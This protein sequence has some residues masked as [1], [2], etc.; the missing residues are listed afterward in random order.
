MKLKRTLALIALTVLLAVSL[1]MFGGSKTKAAGPVCSVPGDYASIQAAVNDPGCLQINVAAGGYTENVVVNRAVVL[2]GAQAGNPVSGR[3][4][5][6]AAESTLT[7][8]I[9]V[10]AAG[11][12]ID[13]FSQTNPGQGFG[14]LIKTAGSNTVIKNNIID[15]IG[16]PTST[17]FEGAQAIY[18]ENGPDNVSILDNI[19]RNIQTLQRSAKGVLIG[20]SGS[21]DPSLNILIKGNSISNVQSGWRGA[22][23]I[24]ANNGASTAPAATGFTT[25]TIQ[26]NTISNLAGGVNPD[27]LNPNRGWAHAIGLEGDT[28]NVVVTGNSISNVVDANPTPSADAIAVLFED[29]PS[30]STGQVNNNNFTSVEFGIAVSPALVGTPVNGTCNWWGSASGPGPVGPGT[31]AKVSPNVNYT[32]WL[33]S[34]AP[35]GQCVGPDSDNDGITDSADNCPTTANP[36]QENADNDSMGDVCDSDD[37]NDGVPDTCDVDSTPGPDVDQ[38]GIVDGTPCDTVIGPPTKEQC[39]NGGW[40]FFNT[41]RKFKNQGDCIQY[42]NTGK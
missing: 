40:Q 38:D 6:N 15:T 3:T 33:T 16:S 36:G 5:G 42:A 22:Y 8:Q 23:G 26:N 41:P 19:M 34:S 17:D 18:L 30:F 25:V 9:T 14:V 11:V 20:D 2:N 21:A 31:G 29:N 35:G 27:P 24:Q 13:G 1:M 4:F 32:P 39:K 10:Q 7:G 37:D 12:T 28:P